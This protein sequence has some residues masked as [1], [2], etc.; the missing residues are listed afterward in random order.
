MTPADLKLAR[1]R[2]GLSAE[3][4]AAMGEILG[5]RVAQS[6]RTVR[7]WERGDRTIPGPVKLLV[8]LALESAA[9]RRSLGLQ[10]W[11]GDVEEIARIDALEEAA[12]AN[13]VEGCWV[14]PA[15]AN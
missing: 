9:V 6:G 1:Y 3:G 7:R 2:L 12:E 4:L 11:V 13:V 5:A 10:E 15:E 8:R 14:E